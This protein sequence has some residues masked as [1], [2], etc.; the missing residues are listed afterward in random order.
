MSGL[1]T[2]YELTKCIRKLETHLAAANERANDEMGSADH[3]HDEFK[4]VTADLTDRDAVIVQA[5]RNA[6][7][8]YSHVNLL[9]NLIRKRYES[10]NNSL[11]PALIEA[12][13]EYAAS[14]AAWKTAHKTVQE[15]EQ[16]ANARGKSLREMKEATPT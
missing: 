4:K 13:P 6:R 5:C 3:W 14:W 2:K 11:P 10:G 8:L 7:T 16:A 9:Q 1:T 15:A 12:H